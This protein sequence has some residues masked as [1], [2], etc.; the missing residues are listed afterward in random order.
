MFKPIED[1]KAPSVTL[2]V[3]GVA[4]QARQGQT[5]ALALMEAG[6]RTLRQTPVSGQPRSILCLMGVCFDC[7]VQIDGQPNVQS[8]MVTV[9]DG[10]QVRIMTGARLLDCSK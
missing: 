4:I 6:Y 1:V 3:E 9:R 2:H 7:L 10:M 5:V 8:C